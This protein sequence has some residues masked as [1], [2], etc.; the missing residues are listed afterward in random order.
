MH[1][2]PKTNPCSVQDTCKCNGMKFFK[3][4]PHA[5]SLDIVVPDVKLSRNST[6]LQ[7][8]LPDCRKIRTLHIRWKFIQMSTFKFQKKL[9]LAHHGCTLLQKFMFRIVLDYSYEM[10]N[11]EGTC[12]DDRTFHFRIWIKLEWIW[13]STFATKFTKTW[14]MDVSSLKFL[15]TSVDK[16]Q[17]FRTCSIFTGHAPKLE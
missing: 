17:V 8:H 4:L 11:F 3:M 2:R 6:C 12:T 13:T 1:F 10:T 15:K 16:F 14:T 9:K 7:T 5:K